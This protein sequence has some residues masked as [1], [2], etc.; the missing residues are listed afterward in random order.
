MESFEKI[1]L[2]HPVATVILLAIGL[3]GHIPARVA[4]AP[5]KGSKLDRVLAI[6]EA[7]SLDVL[8]ALRKRATESP[9]V[10]ILEAVSEVRIV[11]AD[12]SEKT[13]VPSGEQTTKPVTIEREVQPPPKPPEP[14]S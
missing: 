1:A 5:A 14:R 11:P 3:L 6:W 8:K 7:L 12:E 10:K 9:A 13:P 2:E 4:F